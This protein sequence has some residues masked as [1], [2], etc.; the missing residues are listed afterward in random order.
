MQFSADRRTVARNW[1]QAPVQIETVEGQLVLPE[2]QWM[3]H[4]LAPDGTRK[5]RVPL[6]TADGRSLLKLASEHQ[7]MWYLLERLD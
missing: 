3:C 4:A 6:S 5:H 7:T 1:G 2:G